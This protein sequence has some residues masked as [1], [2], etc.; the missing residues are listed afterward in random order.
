[1]SPKRSFNKGGQTASERDLYPSIIVVNWLKIN[2]H[3]GV[4]LIMIMI[5]CPLNKDQSVF[6]TE[7][8][9][10]M[11]HT[12]TI[13]IVTVWID[14]RKTIPCRRMSKRLQEKQ[15]T[16]HVSDESCTE[17]SL[18]ML[19]ASSSTGSDDELLRSTVKPCKS[20]SS[21]PICSICESGAGSCLLIQCQNSSCSRSFH[22]FC[23][24]PP[25][26]DTR[27]TLECPLCKINEASLA[28]GMEVYASKKIQRLVGCR[29]V[30]LQ[31]SDFQYQILVKW[32]LLS[33]HHDC[34]VPLDWL[35]V[36]D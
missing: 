19:S 23:L 4:A 25:M 16:D 5:T 3:H 15:K 21:G 26:Q 28:K 14:H 17:A 35:L 33:H 12:T 11:M 32:Q 34:W 30:I 6:G 8:E 31:E 29:R 1:M 20:T 13:L 24:S 9:L 7:C 36:F 18:C 2:T 27:G 22:T 10:D